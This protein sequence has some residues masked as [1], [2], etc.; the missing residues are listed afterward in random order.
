MGN[1]TAS[2]Q[3]NSDRIQMKFRDLCLIVSVGIL[4]VRRYASTMA[5]IGGNLLI[6]AFLTGTMSRALIIKIIC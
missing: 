3:N 5:R 4:N 1:H 6:V 2:L